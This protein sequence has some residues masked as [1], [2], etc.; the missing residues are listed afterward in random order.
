LV[1]GLAGSESQALSDSQDGSANNES[2]RVY[3]RILNY[4]AV[5]RDFRVR[6]GDHEYIRFC[7]FD[8]AEMQRRLDREGFL[9]MTCLPILMSFNRTGNGIEVSTKLQGMLV[10]IVEEGQTFG[11][12][13]NRVG[14]F[15][16]M[17]KF[18]DVSTGLNFCRGLMGLRSWEIALRL[19]FGQSEDI[20][21][22]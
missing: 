20:V 18:G 5:A 15:S 14:Y 3:L 10:E 9:K 11:R 21:L 16:A 22:V 12:S 2:F 13:Y 1:V 8:T 6:I 17:S 7:Y 4:G 19:G